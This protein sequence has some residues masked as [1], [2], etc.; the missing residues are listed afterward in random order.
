MYQTTDKREWGKFSKH[1]LNKI[2]WAKPGKWLATATAWPQELHCQ[3]PWSCTLSSSAR[4]HSQLPVYP[5]SR[6]QRAWALWSTLLSTTPLMSLSTAMFAM[7]NNLLLE[8]REGKHLFHREVTSFL[9]IQ[10]DQLVKSLKITE[11]T[12]ATIVS[13]ITR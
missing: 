3:R 8:L 5:G 7:W 6:A 12:K 1:Q 10:S 4:V 13:I 9:T 11:L 2:M